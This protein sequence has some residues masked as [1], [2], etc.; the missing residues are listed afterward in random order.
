MKKYGHGHL[1]VDGESSEL[2]ENI[3]NANICQNFRVVEGYFSGNW[4]FF[5]Q[6][7]YE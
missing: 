1:V 6:R 3:T 4:N 2:S 5:F 7:L